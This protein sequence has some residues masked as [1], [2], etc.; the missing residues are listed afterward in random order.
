M[1]KKILVLEDEK[2]VAQLYAKRLTAEGYETKVGHN[3]LDGIA[4]LKEMT[5]DLVLLDIN[6][7]EM[8]GLEFYQHI[9]G[10]KDKPPFPVL[11]L[12][13]RTD[14]EAFFR[15]FNVDG[16]I[17][18]PF[19]ASRL[20]TEVDIILK[21]GYQKKSDGTL[22]SIAIVDNDKNDL[23]LISEAFKAAGYKTSTADSA[24]AGIE[25]IMENPP[26][27]AI[28]KLGLSDLSGDMIVF[29]LQQ[30][31]KTK[32][33]PCVIYAPRS[34]Q[35]YDRRVWS[36]ISSKSGVKKLIEYDTPKDLI[37]A[38]VDIFKEEEKENVD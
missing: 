10:S 5:P 9:C 1:S 14:L 24:V 6:M 7:P 15:D 12:S 17:T 18:K 19:A 4:F 20:V 31:A 35:E 25:S 37:D 29:K 3:G 13:A 16:F 21:K 27:V 8:G 23:S 34:G 32:S 11:V 38:A 26:D 28:I 2:E 30:M 33:V 22:R 36:G